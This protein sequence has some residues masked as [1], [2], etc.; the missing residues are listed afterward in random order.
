MEKRILIVLVFILITFGCVEKVDINNESFVSEPVI[1]GKLHSNGDLIIRIFKTTQIN[2]ESSNAVIENAKITLWTEDKTGKKKIVHDNFIFN[3]KEKAYRPSPLGTMLSITE[4]ETYWIDISLP[5]GLNYVSTAEVMPKTVD[6]NDIVYLKNQLRAIFKDEKNV[7]N[8]YLVSF[9][10]FDKH[11]KLF[12]YN[13]SIESNDILF[14]GNDNAY[15][16]AYVFLNIDDNNYEIDL[17][18]ESLSSS[19]YSFYQK[20]IEQDYLNQGFEDEEGDPGWLFS[21][22]PV[23]LYGNIKEKDSGKKALG[24]FALSSLVLKN[25]TL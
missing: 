15:I 17:K 12:I 6:I 18:M 5:N 19:S 1:Y 8:Y 7:Q 2:E 13:S 11:E 4:G 21:R 16:E 14:D 10:V 23:N 9:N 20:F 24:Q 22:P 3:I 25:K